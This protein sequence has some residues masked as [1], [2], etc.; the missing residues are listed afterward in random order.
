MTENL[1]PEDRALVAR[2]RDQAGDYGLYAQKVATSHEK[3]WGPLQQSV[4]LAADR[5]VSLSRAFVVMTQDRDGWRDAAETYRTSRDASDRRAA[6]ADK[7]IEDAEHDTECKVNWTEP[8]DH[9]YDDECDCFK[10]DYAKAKGE[11]L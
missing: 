3:D 2:L 1:T 5:I 4:W 7:A 11:L 10:A 6:L 8:S 9:R